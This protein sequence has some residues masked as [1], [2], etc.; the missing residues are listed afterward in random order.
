MG[1]PNLLE[2]SCWGGEGVM[3]QIVTVGEGESA[4]NIHHNRLAK[5]ICALLPNIRVLLIKVVERD[6][7]VRKIGWWDDLLARACV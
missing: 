2:G 6:G 5:L 3:L 1:A 4:L 7:S